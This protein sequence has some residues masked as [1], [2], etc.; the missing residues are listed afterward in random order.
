MRTLITNGRI[1]DA[2]PGFYDQLRPGKL[3]KDTDPPL[4]VPENLPRVT[5]PNKQE[6]FSQTPVYASLT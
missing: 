6:R 1:Y 2:D 3:P 5:E 4:K